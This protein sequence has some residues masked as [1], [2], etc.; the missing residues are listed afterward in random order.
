MTRR[1]LAESPS[2]RRSWCTSGAARP[3][4]CSGSASRG[5]LAAGVVAAA[6]AF[7]LVLMG[8]AY[9]FGSISGCHVNPAVTLGVLLAKRIDGRARV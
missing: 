3:R 6:L 9:A 1:L 2:A 4:S 8:L 5:V 7:G